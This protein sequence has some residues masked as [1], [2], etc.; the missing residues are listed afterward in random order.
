MVIA[1]FVGRERELGLHHG[2]HYQQQQERRQHFR[3][4]SHTTFRFLGQS[5]ISQFPKYAILLVSWNLTT[6][7]CAPPLELCID[8][9]QQ[10]STVATV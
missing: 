2:G 5:L 7:I 1:P 4:R 6:R 8:H 10:T 9:T 3:M